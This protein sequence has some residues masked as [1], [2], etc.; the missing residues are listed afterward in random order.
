MPDATTPLKFRRWLEVQ[1]LAETIFDTVNAGLRERGLLLN[2]GT[3][4]DA[5][6]LAAPSS[7]NT[8]TRRATRKCIRPA[9]AISGTSA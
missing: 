8:R 5:T 2:Q 7:T 1:G 6:I 3:V 9:R 4:A